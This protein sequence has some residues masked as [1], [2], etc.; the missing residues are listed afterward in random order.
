MSN[1]K[2]GD[3]VSAI[4]DAIDGVVLSIK[5]NQ[6]S[7]ET[8][9]G[10][11]LTFLENELVKKLVS[12]ELKGFI[13]TTDII[14]IKTE[15]QEQKKRNFV[16]ESKSKKE[17]F[18]LEVDLHIEKLIPNKKG[19]SNFDILNIQMDTAKRQ[20]DFAIKNRI[21]KLVLIHGVGEGILK[22][23]LDFLLKRYE[24]IRIQ[25]GNYQKYGL[26]ATEIYFL[27]KKMI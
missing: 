26:G 17:V 24:N 1:F 21:P 5:L 7:I 9:D 12:N 10:F 2:I 8:T 23:E 14:K 15:K 20:I 22:S 3:A 6:I 18:T 13:S 11:I 4:D 27:Q 16:K 19:H 25:E